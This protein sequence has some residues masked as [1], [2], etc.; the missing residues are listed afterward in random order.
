MPTLLLYGDQDVRAPLEVG[1]A[2]H[3]AIPGSR[4]VVLHGVGHA[5]PVEAAERFNDEVRSFLHQIGA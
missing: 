4:M 1:E 3:A 2:I 5:S